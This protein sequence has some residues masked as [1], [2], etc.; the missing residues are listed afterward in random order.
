MA[1]KT[2]TFVKQKSGYKSITGLRSVAKD[3]NKSRG[4]GE[5]VL[6]FQTNISDFPYSI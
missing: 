3:D 6:L 5:V 4:W 1:R 2:F